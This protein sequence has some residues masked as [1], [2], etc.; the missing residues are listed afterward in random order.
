[1]TDERI[2]RESAKLGAID[3]D[4]YIEDGR[5]EATDGKISVTGAIRCERDCELVGEVEARE[6]Y[7][8]WGDVYVR[9]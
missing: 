6:I 8:P 5:V 1:M 2:Y 4:L 3:G 9:G 7:S